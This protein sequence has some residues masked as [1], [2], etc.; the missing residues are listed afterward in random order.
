MFEILKVIGGYVIP[1]G[2]EA[3]VT[4]IAAN[5]VRNQSTLMKIAAG[6]SSLWV[7]WWIS[8]K[9][10]DYLDSELDRFKGK[11]DKYTIGKGDDAE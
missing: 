10:C 1:I 3:V 7:G 4:S 6:I 9:A 2:T 8:D 11:W 5:A